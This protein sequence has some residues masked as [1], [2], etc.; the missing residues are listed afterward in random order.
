VNKA[1]N[2]KQYPDLGTI[3][4][5]QNRRAKNLAIRINQQGEVRVTVP[6]YISMKRAE[7]FVW[8]KKAWITGKLDELRKRSV[9]FIALREGDVLDVRGRS[10]PIELKNGDGSLEEA[11]WRILLQEAREYLPGRAE[12]LAKLHG[13]S[14]SGVKVRRMKTR[15]GSCTPKNSINLNSWLMML[16]DY[17][18][19]YVILHELVHTRHR[20]HSSGFWEYLDRLTAGRSKELR[21]ELRGKQIM[22]INPE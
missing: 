8:S 3:R 17:L 5:V 14:I 21:K 22:S 6:R 7:G 18:S 9:S 20:D 1:E 2:I 16:P 13:F 19:D 4:F 12:A 10:I 11:I 15:W